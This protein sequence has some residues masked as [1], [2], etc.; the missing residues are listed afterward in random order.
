MPMAKL[1][2]VKPNPK[3]YKANKKYEFAVDNRKSGIEHIKSKIPKTHFP[4]NLSVRMPAGRR[5]IA[6]VNTGIPINHPI[7]TGPQSNTWLLTRKV[8][9]TPFSIHTAKQT[10]KAR[11]LK[12]S[13]LWD[14][15]VAT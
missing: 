1:T 5:K 4:P 9:N 10:V 11:V 2:P 14:F 6:P 15:R 12:N 3:L 13:I 8:T 7:F